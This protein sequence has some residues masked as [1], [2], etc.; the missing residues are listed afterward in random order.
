MTI[1][2]L[3]SCPL[4]P[5][6][7]KRLIN[8]VLHCSFTEENTEDTC[9]VQRDVLE[10]TGH[11]PLTVLTQKFANLHFNGRFTPKPISNTDSQIL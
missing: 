1:A 3:Y 8:L 5:C 4:S 11:A 7:H 10:L 9:F 2:G 6:V